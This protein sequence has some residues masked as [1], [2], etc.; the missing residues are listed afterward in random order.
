MSWI[1]QKSDFFLFLC[2]QGLDQAWRLS[3]QI[4]KPEPNHSNESMR[5]SDWSDSLS[6]SVL[7]VRN[8]LLLWVERN[9]PLRSFILKC[10]CEQISLFI[11]DAEEQMGF[12]QLPKKKSTSATNYLLLCG[13]LHLSLSQC[14]RSQALV[15]RLLMGQRRIINLSFC[16]TTAL[17]SKTTRAF[18]HTL[19]LSWWIMHRGLWTNSDLLHNWN[20]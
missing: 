2:E 18:I 7:A 11:C 19:M 15:C 16:V 14:W 12:Y 1:P 9:D 17:F 3:L 4:T 5:W 20:S 8:T 10:V 6:L 13:S